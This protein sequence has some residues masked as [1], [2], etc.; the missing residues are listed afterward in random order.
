MY[1]FETLE[2]NVGKYYNTNMENMDFKSET[3]IL[4]LIRITTNKYVFS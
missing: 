2:N 3:S 1:M 4:K